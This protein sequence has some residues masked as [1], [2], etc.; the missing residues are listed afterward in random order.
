[1]GGKDPEIHR[2]ATAFTM[3]YRPFQQRKQTYDNEPSCDDCYHRESAEKEA[4]H[5]SGPWRGSS[6]WALK[7]LSD[8]EVIIACG[9][10]EEQEPGQQG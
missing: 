1:M 4:I 7:G 8:S 10:K 9:Q 5:S 2:K 3:E 6:V